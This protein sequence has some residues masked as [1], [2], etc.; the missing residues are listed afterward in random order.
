[1]TVVSLAIGFSECIKV[2][3]SAVVTSVK[4]VAAVLPI[5]IVHLDVNCNGCY[6]RFL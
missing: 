2:K 1:M 6:T 4:L 3:G 5:V